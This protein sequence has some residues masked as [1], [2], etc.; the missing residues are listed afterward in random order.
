MA[1]NKICQIHFGDQ[2]DVGD[3]LEVIYMG[4]VVGQWVLCGDDNSVV[5]KL[6]FKPTVI[7][8]CRGDDER[9]EPKRYKSV[10]AL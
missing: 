4:E 2:Y 3:Y 7:T 6:K 9:R 5:H 10:P 8:Y 1:G